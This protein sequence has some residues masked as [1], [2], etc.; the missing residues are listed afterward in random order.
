MAF[1]PN[2]PALWARLRNSIEDLLLRFW[3]EGA[4][5]GATAAEAF[6]VRCGRNTMTQSDLDA[7]RLVVEIT[8]RP[9]AAIERITVV[10]DL[11]NAARAETSIRESA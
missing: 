4:F 8:L 3:N 9:A 11:G 7:G 10:L 1:D 5:L 2:G 6:S